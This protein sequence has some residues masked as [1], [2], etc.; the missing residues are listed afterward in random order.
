VV[1]YPLL[2]LMPASIVFVALDDGLHG[3]PLPP[4]YAMLMVGLATVGLWRI[5]QVGVLLHGD[6]IKVRNF[7]R[8][9]ILRWDDVADVGDPLDLELVFVLKSGERVS[10]VVTTTTYSGYEA[11][12]T[13]R[14]FLRLLT[15]LRERLAVAGRQ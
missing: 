11:Y 13:R 9:R 7:Y 10:T 14:Q 3:R 2:V 8:T 4:W 5:T 6:R 1:W 15:Q 12:L